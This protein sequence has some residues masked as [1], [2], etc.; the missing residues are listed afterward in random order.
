LPLQLV[1]EDGMERI[2]AR[3]VVL[4]TAADVE[5]EAQRMGVAPALLMDMAG[6]HGVE[7]IKLEGVTP[8]V[9]E[10][11]RGT[12]SPPAGLVLACGGT[13]V[14][15]SEEGQKEPSDPGP[16]GLRILVAASRALLLEAASRLDSLGGAGSDAA[17]AIRSTLFLYGGERLGTTRCGNLTLEWGKRTY[18]M[19]II[20]VTPDSFSGDGLGKNVDAALAQ[21]ER[22][23]QAGVDI[24][25]VGGESTRPGHEEVPVQEELER[26]IPVVRRLVKEMPVPISVD[27][28]RLLVVQEALEAG[29]HMINDVWGLRRTEGLGSLAAAYNVPIVL[30]HNRRADATRTSLGGHFQRVEYDD[31]MGEIV[32]ELRESVELALRSNVRWENIIV[33][34]GIGFGKTPSQNLVVMRRL[35]EVRSLGRPILMGTSR[36]SVIGLTLG[37][38]VEERVEGTGATVAVSICNGA[39]IVRVH[40]VKE[41]VRISRMTDAIVRA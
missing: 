29:A 25:D 10:A 13:G 3:V 36:K 37:L 8:E 31:M 40:D 20:N 16:R 15:G 19:G 24:L 17:E 18:V 5:E 34:P 38:P 22:F 2:A 32:Q 14:E 21:A 6:A 26:V 23:V 28:Y 33:D 12:I 30:M 7:G 39:D 4:P 9:A 27:S 1:P 11:L 35:K 41:M